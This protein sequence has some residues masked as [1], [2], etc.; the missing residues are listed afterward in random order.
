[1]ELLLLAAA[2]ISKKKPSK[3]MLLIWSKKESSR[4]FWSIELVECN[5]IGKW[6]GKHWPIHF[7]CR[8]EQTWNYQL[9]IHSHFVHALVRLFVCLFFRSAFDHAYKRSMLMLILPAREWQSAKQSKW[10]NEKDK[11]RRRRRWRGNNT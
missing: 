3:I 2:G 8:F 1:M 10:I 11:R 7:R 4:E 5:Q 6:S 9:L